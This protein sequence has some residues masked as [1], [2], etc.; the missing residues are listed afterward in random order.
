MAPED[1]SLTPLDA[2]SLLHDLRQPLTNIEAC[3]YLLRMFLEGLEDPR[4]TE[5]LETIDR[6]AAE[7]GRILL[8]ALQRPAQP[9]SRRFTNPDSAALT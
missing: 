7:I 9:E 2:A 1:G 3:T 8:A 4:V 6:Q 5:N